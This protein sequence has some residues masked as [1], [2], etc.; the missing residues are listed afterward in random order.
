VD[1]ATFRILDTLATGL[2]KTFSINQ[3]TAKIKKTHG[4]AHYPN[5]YKKLHELEKQQILTLTKIGKSSLTSL[6]FE[7]YLLTDLLAEREI[8][9][10]ISFLKIRTNLQ[11][12]HQ[13]L[14]KRLGDLCPIKAIGSI[15]PRKN[16]K[17]NKIEL[18]ILQQNTGESTNIQNE[19]NLIH[20]RLNKIQDK[21]NIKINS[22]ILDTHNFS[23]LLESDEINPL[24]EFLSNMIIFSDP[25]AFWNE[26]RELK[27]KG[28]DIRALEK[29]TRPLDIT[30]NDLIY[31]LARFGYTEF[32]SEVRQG[33]KYCI[34]YIITSLLMSGDARRIEAIPIII[35][36][37]SINSNLLVFLAQKFGQSGKLLGLLKILENMKA[38]EEVSKAISLLEILNVNE[39]DSDAEAIQQKM[40]LYNASYQ[41]TG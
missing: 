22:L 16:L 3:L 7:N 6:N 38:E 11:M 31:N 39:I 35:A 41:K 32:G 25:Q 29:E 28:I 10:K 33:R 13:D 12:L 4:T 27:E 9:K 40:R 26:I 23:T 19:T 17:L 14:D 30:E 18:F 24:R 8:K 1:A 20:S 15:N 34:E 36:K 2:G 37:N 5:I 21:Y